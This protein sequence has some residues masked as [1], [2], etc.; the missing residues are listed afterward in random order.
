MAVIILF[1]DKLDEHELLLREYMS[2]SAIQMIQIHS[3]EDYVQ[4]FERGM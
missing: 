3:D 4:V 2:Q 1:A